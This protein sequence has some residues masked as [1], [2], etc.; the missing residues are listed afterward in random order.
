MMTSTTPLPLKGIRVTDATASFAGPYLTNMMGTLGAEVIKVDSLQRLD[1]WR[2]SATQLLSPRDKIWEWSPNWNAVNTDKLCI[3]LNLTDP[4]GVDVFRR[5][6]SI[7]DVVTENYTP[8]VMP[9]FGLDYPVLRDLNP[10]LV[11]ISL[12]AHGATGPW[13]NVPGFAVP[14]EL[15]SGMAELMGYPD[16]APMHSGTGIADPIAG[17][18]GMIAVMFALLQRQA[19]GV[20]QYID[21]S[22]VEASTSLLGDAIVENSMNGVAPTRRGNRHPIAAPHGYYQCSGDDLWVSISVSS[23]EEWSA[24]CGVMGDPPWSRDERFAHADGRRKNQD[25][26]DELI[27]SWTIQHDH[28]EVMNTLQQAGV[29]A[30]AVL[31]SAELLSDPHLKE[32]GTF[33]VVQRDL[34]GPRHYPV[35]TAP[36]HFSDFPLKIRKPAPFLGE[37]NEYVLGELLGMSQREIQS[38]SDDQVIGTEP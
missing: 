5:L 25:E 20:G 27:E 17:M 12:P 37:H 10:G 2:P 22:Q 33:Q 28:Y 4:R 29:T 24:L 30:C 38:M 34:I 26:L 35:P 9:N 32:R 7:S 16:D 36:M 23:E 14:N 13:K 6:A 1:L 21:L 11:M 3:T 8:R 15:M 19:T 18:N 31:T